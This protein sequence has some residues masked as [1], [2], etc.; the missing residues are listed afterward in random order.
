MVTYA[1]FGA[2]DHTCQLPRI[3]QALEI[4]GL[5]QNLINP[6]FIY[7]NDNGGYKDALQLKSRCPDSKVI[8]NV[9]DIPEHLPNVGQCIEAY[10]QTLKYADVVTSISVFV[11]DQLIKFLGQPSKIIYNPIQNV[12]LSSDSET[13]ENRPSDLLFVGRLM[14]PN[15]RFDVLRQA[16]YLSGRK[17]DLV[18]QHVQNIDFSRL[19]VDRSFFN[20][21]VSLLNQIYHSHKILL[22]PSRIEGLGLPPIEAYICGCI[23]ILSTDNKTAREFFDDKYFVNPTPYDINLKIKDI[24]KNPSYYKPDPTKQLALYN[25]FNSLAIAKNIISVYEQI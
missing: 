21:N 7:A 23:P 20:I 11:Q 5:R 3:I 15:K 16:A 6:S 8:F 12:V 22:F 1:A 2:M 13:F 24:Y 9:L 19:Y 18:T 4:L 14:D 17:L 25:Q 10:S